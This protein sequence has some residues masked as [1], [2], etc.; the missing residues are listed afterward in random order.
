MSCY[1]IKLI[2]GETLMA[3]VIN[4]DESHLYINNPILIEFTS[5]SLGSTMYSTYWI[6]LPEMSNIVPLKASHIITYTRTGDSM[7]A[8]YERTINKL[9]LGDQE[10][11]HPEPEVDQEE[12]EK[13]E[14]YRNKIRLIRAPAANTVH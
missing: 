4:S 6:P 8:F 14:E 13:L 7:S 11:E 2:N 3:S 1:L 9:T 10:E 12:K 5:T